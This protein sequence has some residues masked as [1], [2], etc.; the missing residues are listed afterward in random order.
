[1]SA[2]IFLASRVHVQHLWK[3]SSQEEASLRWV[4]WPY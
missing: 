4:R 3:Q 1:M 2:T